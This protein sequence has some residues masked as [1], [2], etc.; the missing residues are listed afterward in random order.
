[1]NG[2][3]LTT[4]AAQQNVDALMRKAKFESK[5]TNGMAVKLSIATDPDTQDWDV[6]AGAVATSSDKNIGF[7]CS[8]EI[9]RLIIGGI[10]AGADPRYF[11]VP[12]G[13]VADVCMVNLY[14]VFQV[15]VDC[16]EENYTPADVDDATHVVVGTGG[17][18]R[19]ATSAG[20]GR[21]FELG[22]EMPIH[23]GNEDVPAW[24]IGCIA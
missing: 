24:V 11:E 9:N 1:M 16:F 15:S 19:A 20:S 5:V 8:P 23:I 3:L 17:K 7:V 6:F 13:K 18:L 22:M 21:A 12:A 4:H 10:Y 2:I 14:D